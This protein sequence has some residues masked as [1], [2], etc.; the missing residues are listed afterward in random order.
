MRSASGAVEHPSNEQMAGVVPFT[1][2]PHPRDIV[3][4]LVPEYFD[5]V[6]QVLGPTTTSL[7]RKDCQH[8]HLEAF[9]DVLDRGFDA[10]EQQAKT[11][12]KMPVGEYS[13]F[14]HF[15]LCSCKWPQRGENGAFLIA[16]LKRRVADADDRSAQET[17]LVDQIAK[18]RLSEG[19]SL[20][21][22]PEETDAVGV[23]IANAACAHAKFNGEYQRLL[24]NI[25]QLL[26]KD[27]HTPRPWVTA[28]PA[29]PYFEWWDGMKWRPFPK[30]LQPLRE[31]AETVHKHVAPED[32]E[33]T[34]AETCFR[35]LADTALKAG[36][37]QWAPYHSRSEGAPDVPKSRRIEAQ[38]KECKRVLHGLLDKKAARNT[39]LKMAL[40]CARR[41]EEDMAAF[42]GDAAAEP[43]FAAFVRLARNQ[44]GAGG[45]GGGASE[46]DLVPLVLKHVTKMHEAEYYAAID[47][48]REAIL[49]KLQNVLVW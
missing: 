7:W 2:M 40:H 10:L 49:E 24:H 28:G 47:E 6:G 12:E 20:K 36:L 44:G 18:L 16:Y 22:S 30:Q 33:R 5:P 11:G 27:D 25:T 39:A 48:W 4:G 37:R 35:I 38:Y 14:M 34:L 41:K 13:H 8:I 31:R 3:L 1:P 19:P 43:G 9:V 32:P 46:P 15:L 42:A 17:G 45:G 29:P 21:R 26:W 23:A